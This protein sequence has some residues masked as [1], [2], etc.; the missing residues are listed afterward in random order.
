[1]KKTLTFVALVLAFGIASADTTPIVGLWEKLPVVGPNDKL[2]AR[3]SYIFT[4]KK[5][6]E[7]TIFSALQ[8]DSAQ[9]NVLCCIEVSNLTAIDLKN[10]LVK[11]AKDP[12]FVEH[13]KSIKGLN[14][15]Y[16][17]HAVDKAGR[18][19]LMNTVMQ[20]EADPMDLSPYTAPVISAKFPKKSALEQ[21]FQFDGMK[22]QLQTKYSDS[23]QKANYEFIINGAAV[24]FSEDSL[25]AE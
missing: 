1:M 6:E 12:T 2:I 3:T 9:L 16:E 20:T 22:I 7:K 25:P 23:S 10:V 13:L 8:D 17:A 5:L 21:Q 14:F 15:V 24:K 18:N 19:E 11:Y 4:N